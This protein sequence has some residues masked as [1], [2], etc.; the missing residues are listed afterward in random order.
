MC[1][2][3]VDT[4]G[5]VY[6]PMSRATGDASL[7]GGDVNGSIRLTATCEEEERAEPELKLDEEDHGAIAWF[8]ESL[9]AKTIYN[10]PEVK[11]AAGKTGSVII[12]SVWK[13]GDAGVGLMVNIHTDSSGNQ[14]FDLNYKCRCQPDG[15]WERKS[16]TVSL[17]MP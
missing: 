9:G 7:T 3:T 15:D 13:N 5:L 14:S 17:S 16:V 1:N 8:L 2:V 4:T 6:N 11:N 12:T 10:R